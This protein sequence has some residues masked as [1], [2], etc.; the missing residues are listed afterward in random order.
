M[1]GRVEAYARL[2]KQG[3]Y[4]DMPFVVVICPGFVVHDYHLP[5]SMLW[6]TDLAGLLVILVYRDFVMQYE[7]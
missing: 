2:N 6:C 7:R 3:E 1:G 4:F 5:S